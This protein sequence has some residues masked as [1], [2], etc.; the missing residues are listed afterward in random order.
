VINYYTV[1]FINHIF[2]KCD[3]FGRIAP[4]LKEQLGSDRVTMIFADTDGK[5]LVLYSNTPM[6]GYDKV[7]Q[8]GYCKSIP[9]S[10]IEPEQLNALKGKD[11]RFYKLWTS[12]TKGMSEGSYTLLERRPS[13]A[14]EEILLPVGDS[15]AYHPSDRLAESLG[16]KGSGFSD[17]GILIREGAHGV[18]YRVIDLVEDLFGENFVGIVDESIS[19]LVGVKFLELY[20]PEEARRYIAEIEKAETDDTHMKAF[21][22]VLNRRSQ[23]E[24]MA[25]VIRLLNSQ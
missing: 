20:Y 16:N 12:F 18:I 21:D 19:Q 5:N 22:M 11:S 4:F 1:T 14:A 6:R 24:E 9:I 13:D 10:D 15:Y 8:L 3:M 17:D 25:G 2:S 23:V 7:T